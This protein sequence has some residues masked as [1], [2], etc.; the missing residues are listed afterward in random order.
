[1]AH[2]STDLSNKFHDV[3]GDSNYVRCQ[4]KDAH[5]GVRRQDDGTV[6]I[7]D[8]LRQVEYIY[9]GNICEKFNDRDSARQVPTSIPDNARHLLSDIKKENV[10]ERR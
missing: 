5:I 8:I 10:V 4:S 1:M 9:R 7:T 6:A 2:L 3:L